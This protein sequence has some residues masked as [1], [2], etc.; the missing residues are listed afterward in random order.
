MVLTAFVLSRIQLLTGLIKIFFRDIIRNSS[1]VAIQVYM[2]SIREMKRFLVD[3][4]IYL[5]NQKLLFIQFIIIICWGACCS[6]VFLFLGCVFCVVCLC[7]MSCFQC[8]MSLWIVHLRLSLR[9]SLSFSVGFMVKFM[10]IKGIDHAVRTSIPFL[11]EL[12]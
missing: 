12:M 10:H 4:C 11:V 8:C 2:N 1:K 5:N 3:V 9:F 6:P 7:Y